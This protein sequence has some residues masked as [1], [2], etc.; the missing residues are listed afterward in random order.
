MKSIA[1]AFLC[2]TFFTGGL[3]AETE[4]LEQRLEIVNEEIQRLH[5]PW[6][7]TINHQKRGLGLLIDRKPAVRIKAPAHPRTT[8]LP[9]AIDWRDR[10]GRDYIT[11]VK[12]QY[13]CG[14][15]WAFSAIGTAEAMWKIEKNRP[16]LDPDLSEQELVS[17]SGAG[18]CDG[19][20]H[21]EA[22]AY[23]RTHGV[24]P[25]YCFSYSASDLACA[26]CA[27]SFQIRT[28]I[29][30]CAYVCLENEDVTAIK[31]ALQTG[32]VATSMEVYDDW[33]N[34]YESGIYVKTPGAVVK[35]YHAVVIVGYDD[36][37]SCWIVKNSWGPDWG[38]NG[39][40]RIRWLQHGIG[41]PAGLNYILGTYTMSQE[42]VEIT[43]VGLN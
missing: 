10:N 5:L 15:C 14:A 36:A 11:P 8:A 13:G 42:G 35:G 24:S 39:Y 1:F 26:P 19:G 9:A 23:M 31:A 4:D 20:Y 41:G 2:L 18:N 27:E 16:D 21:G 40:F 7:T 38:E 6:T 12:D 29:Q 25:E 37:T 43:K 30:D 28:T 32:P 34:Y 17:C 22:A 3:P 33:Y